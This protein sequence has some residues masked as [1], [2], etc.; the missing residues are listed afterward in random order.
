MNNDYLPLC[1]VQ[2]VPHGKGIRFMH[3]KA[4]YDITVYIDAIWAI[5]SECNGRNPMKS[6]ISKVKKNVE[7]IDDNTI[8][9]IINDLSSLGVIVDSREAYQYFH[10][11]TNNPTYFPTNLSPKEIEEYNNTTRMAVYP[12]ESLPVRSENL[13]LGKLQRKRRSCRSFSSESVSLAQLGHVL[14][15]SYSLSDHTTP[16]PGGLYPLKIYF[17]VTI[18]MD[19]I[20]AGYYEYDPEKCRIV[21]MAKTFDREVM[22]YAFDS[23]SLLY[24]APIIIVICGDVKRLSRKYGNRGYR[25]TILEAGHVAQNIHLS[26]VEQ[27][28]SALEYGGFQDNVLS[29]EL[30]IDDTGG[31]PIITIALGVASSEEVDDSTELLTSLYEG[32]VGPNK[33][34]RYST[35]SS[36]NLSEGDISFFESYALCKPSIEQDAKRTYKDRFSG[37]TATTS[38]LARVKSIAEG[39][40][41]YVSGQFRVDKIAKATS[42]NDEWL[43]PSRV[44]PFTDKQYEKMPH[45]Q[46][47][48][49]N[50]EWQWVEGKN[51]S[52]GNI[53]WVPV[54]LVYFPLHSKT[55]GRKLCYQANSSGVAAYTS[56]EEAT[57]R[58]LLELIERDAIMRNWYS[59]KSPSQMHL[60]VLPFHWK[61]RSQYWE[62][63]GRNVY[64]LDHSDSGTININVL[65]VSENEFPCFVSG[66]ASSFS[67][68][69][70]AV[71]KAFQ[72]AEHELVQFLKNPKTRTIKPEK[73]FQPFDNAKL[74]AHPDYLDNLRWLW[75]GE[76]KKAIPIS[77]C[78]AEDIFDKYSTI[79]VQL[80][81]KD[82]PLDVVRV[83][84]DNKLVP[85]NFGYGT[86]HFT[87]PSI[88]GNINPKSIGLPNYFA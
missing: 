68:F 37:G 7:S 69:E 14:V 34:V 58:G 36:S 21:N 41:R 4:Q 85:V 61:R 33:P 71:S 81:F 22:E 86:E 5:I 26:S 66:S 74:Y 15:T 62:S 10:Q 38:T 49:E 55:F 27:G 1:I 3:P 16:S 64:I 23:E 52:N 30:G 18:D 79:M 70:E 82:A 59:R 39:Y 53:V 25:H 76:V 87:H 88:S 28:L 84:S 60:D 6:V 20:K 67:S 47:F 17:V 31:I 72:E 83:L 13:E 63:K 73:V 2:A 12:G 43:H 45:L 78:S 54:D 75:E 11:F 77:D 46:P 50:I 24:N 44:V 40:E 9:S 32:I 80:S 8:Y 29:H 35:L 65:I 19:E 51:I 56:V 57:K 42:L 48:D